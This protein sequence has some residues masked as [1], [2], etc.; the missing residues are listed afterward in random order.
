MWDYMTGTQLSLFCLLL[1]LHIWRRVWVSDLGSRRERVGG[2]GWEAPTQMLRDPG[3]EVGQV[4]NV[5]TWWLQ[6]PPQ[7][8]HHSALVTC[9]SGGKWTQIAASLDFFKRSW[10]CG[11]LSI[12]NSEII[13]K[14]SISYLK[15]WHGAQIHMYVCVQ[16]SFRPWVVTTSLQ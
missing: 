12:W 4:G 15:T 7:S 10:R 9:L 6:I 8:G 11:F 3:S 5:G 1:L 14:N 2:A 13:D 16:V